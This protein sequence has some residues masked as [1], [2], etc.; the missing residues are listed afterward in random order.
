MRV[1][2]K[3]QDG[4][5][6]RRVI[7]EYIR[8]TIADEQQ[9]AF[10]EAYRQAAEPLDA[11]AH[12][13]SYELSRCTEEPGSYILRIEWDSAE[14]HMQGFRRSPEF[15]RFFRH[16]QPYVGDIQEMRHYELTGVR[17]G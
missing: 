4:R 11:S 17:S 14:G 13:L 15:R 16:I 2:A 1:Q 10:V 5:E 12:C 8:Y 7:V 9:E 6:E 3:G